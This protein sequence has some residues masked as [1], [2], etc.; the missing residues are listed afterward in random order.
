MKNKARLSGW[1]SIEL[2]PKWTRVT[3][4]TGDKDAALEQAKLLCK[5]SK[6]EVIVCQVYAT[7]RFVPGVVVLD[8]HLVPFSN[9]SAHA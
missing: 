6:N 1:L 7:C 9:N 5:K 4:H 2:A 8:S 3:R